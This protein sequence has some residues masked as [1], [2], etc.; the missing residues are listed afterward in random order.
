MTESTARPRRAR[1]EGAVY[2]DARRSRWI[3]EKIVGYDG[4]GKPIRKS[5]SGTSQTA[6]LRALRERVRQYEAGLAPGADRYTVGQACEDWLAHGQTGN[7]PSTLQENEYLVRLHVVPHLGGRRLKD[8]TATEVDRWLASLTS[9][10][11]TAR[12]RHL[13]SALNRAV[14]RAMTRGLVERNVVAWCRP[15]KGRPGRPSKS[16]TV[17]Q[18]AAI[19]AHDQHWMHP[20]VVVSLTVGM[21]TDEVRALMWD[22][23]KVHRNDDGTTGLHIE[24][25][26]ADRHG[27][28]TKTRDSR[29]TL[30]VPEVAA[31]AL[32][33]QRDWQALKRSEAGERWVDTGLVFTSGHGTALRA[34]NVRR[35]FRKV[36]EGI[37]GIDPAQWT[38]RELRHSFVSVMS[39]SGVPLEEISRLVGHASTVVTQLV[40][41]HELRPVLQTGARAIDGVFS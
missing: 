28:D 20:Y 6:A 13:H 33:R 27:G 17:E 3:A 36:I 23:V 30:A 40:Y 11:S 7:A 34:D 41:R 22:H 8:L 29:R 14:A 32:A 35:D 12:L 15:P 24:V 26:R 38:P 19:L 10:L 2:W 39:S 16:L 21:R 25:W 31:R 5:G 1:G 37:D 18:S 4:R 9:D